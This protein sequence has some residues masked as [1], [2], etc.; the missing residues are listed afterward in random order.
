V[1]DAAKVC[2]QVPKPGAS[3]QTI[4]LCGNGVCNST[5]GCVD[6]AWPDPP[7]CMTEQAGVFGECWTGVNDGS[8][9]CKKIAKVGASC[10]CWVSP[11]SIGTCQADGSCLQKPSKPVGSACSSACVATGTCSEA[12]LCVGK[13]ADGATC[14][15]YADSDTTPV[16]AD[17]ASYACQA[18]GRCAASPK[19]AGIWCNPGYTYVSKPG[20]AGCDY[21][22]YCDGKGKCVASSGTSGGSCPSGDPCA[23]ATECVAGQCLTKGQVPDGAPCN[24]GCFSGTC[25][26]GACG[27]PGERHAEKCGT[28]TVC[29]T[30]ECCGPF[31][32]PGLTGSISW[33]S[34]LPT[35]SCWK[36]THLGEPCFGGPHDCYIGTCLQN[37]WC[38]GHKAPGG[39]KCGSSD[40]CDDR[41]CFGEQC[42]S[43][44]QLGYVTPNCD[45]GNPCTSDYAWDKCFCDHTSSMTEGW[46]CAPGAHC[47]KG[48]CV[49]D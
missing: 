47:T 15:P 29:L 9:G 13:V 42:V 37:G 39:K 17:C 32:S 6:P 14:T 33:C 7:A 10:G 36:E 23:A 44:V 41:E 8:G 48:N 18:D 26:A 25:T 5:G 16:Q 45:D 34:G 12:G 3:C 46:S 2:T 19:P 11:C 30:N 38:H 49:P 24:M 35:G 31:G 43:P 22:N 21:S 20:M 27:L 4:G 1:C 28:D 40:S